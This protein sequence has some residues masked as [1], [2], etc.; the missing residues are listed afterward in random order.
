MVLTIP[1]NRSR[2]GLQTMSHSAP[3]RGSDPPAAGQDILAALRQSESELEKLMTDV[4]EFQIAVDG[5]RSA[6]AAKEQEIQNLRHEVA[7]HQTIRAC[8]QLEPCVPGVSDAP[9]DDSQ[10]DPE[11]RAF[12]QAKRNGFSTLSAQIADLQSATQPLE[13]EVKSLHQ[14]I[15]TLM[16][17]LANCEKA[18][19]R[20]AS[21]RRK[22][23]Q[24]CQFVAAQIKEADRDIIACRRAVRDFEAA[25]AGLAARLEAIS[26]AADSKS[27]LPSA[28]Q[29]LDRELDAIALD[30]AEV[31]AEIR[32]LESLKADERKA[33]KAPEAEWKQ[34]LEPQLA[35]IEGE[36]VD[37]SRKLRDGQDRL[38]A[39]ESRYQR[40]EPI[41]NKWK[42]LEFQDE[43]SRGI[44]DL[45]RIGNGPAREI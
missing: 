34:A 18:L 44:D 21:R 11:H 16:C 13:D 35:A 8:Q 40:L 42:S 33:E 26:S 30:I 31:D 22:L 12:L 29:H 24:E 20:L 2:F 45:L 5:L 28:V 3:G 10:F 1:I 41:A 23:D 25:R 6:R 27:G 9:I 14:Q 32:E 4:D 15:S 43:I 37:S 39:L 38:N 19:Q 17:E 36:I 7:R